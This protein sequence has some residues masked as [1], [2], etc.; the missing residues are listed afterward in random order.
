VSHKLY[1]L[2]VF[3]PLAS[4]IGSASSASAGGIM[5]DSYTPESRGIVTSLYTHA[6]FL[7]SV[8]GSISGGSLGQA[9]GWR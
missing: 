2:I 1:Q 7:G 3:R 6:P 9:N 4:A 8:L 5:N